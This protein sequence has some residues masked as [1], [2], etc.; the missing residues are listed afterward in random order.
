MSPSRW[1]DQMHESKRVIQILKLL[2]CHTFKSGD[3]FGPPEAIVEDLEVGQIKEITLEF[4]NLLSFLDSGNDL[5][6]YDCKSD[7]SRFVEYWV[8]I[9]LS[10]VQLEQYRGTLLS[11]TMSLCSCSKNDP[12]GALRDVLISTQK[13]CDHP[14]IVDLSLQ[15]F[16][17]KGLP[18]IEYLDVGIDATGKLQLLDR[19][20]SEIKIEVIEE[21]IEFLRS[22]IAVG[23]TF[24]TSEQV[25]MGLKSD[26]FTKLTKQDVVPEKMEHH[27]IQRLL[28]PLLGMLLLISKVRLIKSQLQNVQSDNGMV[29]YLS[30]Y[31]PYASGTLM[32]VD[33]QC[34]SQPPYFSSGYLQQPVPYGTEASGSRPT[35]S[36]K[37]NNFPSMKANG[38]VANKYSLPFDSKPRQS[39][40]PS[41]FSKSL[42]HSQPLKPLNKAS[43]LGSDFP[44]GLQKGSIQST[45]SHHLRRRQQ[46]PSSQQHQ[47]LIKN[48][49]FRQLQ[50][51]SDL[52]SQVKAAFGG[53]RHNEILN[54]R[55][56]GQFQLSELQNQFQQN[57]SED[58]SRGAQ[59]HFLPSG[60]QD[61]FISV[62]KF[63][64]NSTIVTSTVVGCGVSK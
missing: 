30:G 13:C 36:A 40:A 39:A 34:V 26:T 18:E 37:T 35:A 32:G 1:I 9:P 56:S 42:F 24:E 5:I 64:I 57:S 50:L 3:V 20:I 61:V 46:K 58:R 22:E 53:E 28:C 54:S 62:S 19:M 59:L 47:L 7:S 12:V 48:D 11:N 43:H 15:S 52:S 21:K 44:T 23:K 51:T 63:T 10:N 38:T 17:T 60:T 33:G 4:V 45:S 27:L 31:N 2:C 14:Y 8:P 41:N 49:A 16:L 25:T 6:A 55:V 29:Y